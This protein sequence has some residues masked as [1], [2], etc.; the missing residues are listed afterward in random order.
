MEESDSS[1]LLVNFFQQADTQ[2]TSSLHALEL[3]LERGI[4][5]KTRRTD[6]ERIRPFLEQHPTIADIKKQHIDDWFKKLEERFA[7]SS[8]QS[9]AQTIKTFFNWCI[10]H[11]EIWLEKSPAAHLKSRRR[12]SARNKAAPQ[13]DLDIVLNH[14]QKQFAKGDKYALRDWLAIQLSADNGNRLTELATL[15]TKAMVT[16]LKRPYMTK[17]GIAVYTTYSDDGK[18]GS[19]PIRF[20]EYTAAL[21]RELQKTRPRKNKHKVFISLRKPYTPLTTDGFTQIFVRRCKEAGVIPFR[22]HA[23]RHLKGT[24]ITNTLGPKAAATTLNI[25]VETAQIH[26]YN[27]DETSAI[28]AT[29][30]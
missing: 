27:E 13:N 16:A 22:T 18:M 4:R 26:Y 12:R 15:T 5:Q 9:Y 11:P 25:T 6:E 8:R 17:K 29:I 19:V 24:K 1:R 30:I 3:F 20:T 2:I 28:E 7:Y 14:L 10:K 21:F 23:L